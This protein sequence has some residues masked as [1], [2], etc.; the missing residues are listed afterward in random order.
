MDNIHDFEIMNESNEDKV[1]YTLYNKGQPR[2]RMEEYDGRLYVQ[3]L[4]VGPI[5][6][7]EFK[8]LAHGLIEFLL[9]TEGAVSEHQKRKTNTTKKGSRGKSRRT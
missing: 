5:T 2:L 1:Q 4:V 6:V 3:Q 9:I 8:T 7:D